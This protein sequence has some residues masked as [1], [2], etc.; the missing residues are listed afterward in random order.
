MRWQAINAAALSGGPAFP[1]N[2][3][4]SIFST[5][6]PARL[7]SLQGTLPSAH[8]SLNTALCTKS[9]G[10]ETCMLAAFSW[11]TDYRQGMLLP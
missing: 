5:K 8:E 11:S 10:L 6:K 4:S 7:F 2:T 3:R 9:S 1:E